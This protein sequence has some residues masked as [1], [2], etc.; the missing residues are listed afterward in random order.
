MD[1]TCGLQ[2]FYPLSVSYIHG[3]RNWRL[4]KSYPSEVGCNLTFLQIEV[5]RKAQAIRLNNRT[6]LQ[7]V[8]SLL[9][10]LF[11]Y[12]RL[13]QLSIAK[14]LWGYFCNQLLPFLV[15]RKWLTRYIQSHTVCALFF[16]KLS[17]IS[18]KIWQLLSVAAAARTWHLH[19]VNLEN[20]VQTGPPNLSNS[21]A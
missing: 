19:L 21:R 7:L 2:S 3:P 20:R 1:W 13:H 11:F 6:W 18:D 15:I 5:G 10:T 8:C 16:S 4:G 12:K 17:I 14:D 9:Q